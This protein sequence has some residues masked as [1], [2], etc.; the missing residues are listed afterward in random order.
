M[1]DV[2]TLR[3]AISIFPDRA[4]EEIEVRYGK[5]ENRNLFR[6][7][8]SAS[9]FSSL[10]KHLSN[11]SYEEKFQIDK[12][13]A[14]VRYRQENGTELWQRKEKKKTTDILAYGIR[15]SVSS[16]VPSSRE[17]ATGIPLVR[18][19]NRYTYVFREGVS[20]LDISIVREIKEGVEKDTIFEVELE[21]KGGVNDAP[22]FVEDVKT[23]W[24]YLYDSK[25]LYTTIEKASVIGDVN[26]ILF[27]DN[28]DI[29]NPIKGNIDRKII[30]QSRGIKY[31]DLSEVTKGYTVTLKADGKRKLL[32]C[33]KS[34]LWF[35]FPPHE[36]NLFSSNNLGIPVGTILDGELIARE[37]RNKEI[38]S[39]YYYL[40]F[41]CLS[42]PGQRILNVPSNIER[43]NKIVKYLPVSDT[44]K[45]GSDLILMQK[46]DFFPIRGMNDFY[47]LMKNLVPITLE[48][49]DT[50]GSMNNNP[51]RLDGLIFTPDNK[52]YITS[53]MRREVIRRMT[54]LRDKNP[55]MS[56]MRI[57][58]IVWEE[59]KGD[60]KDIPTDTFKWKPEITIDFTVETKRRENSVPPWKP[61]SRL[62]V[63]NKKNNLVLFSGSRKIPFDQNN[64]ENE[65]KIVVNDITKDITSLRVV[66]YAWRND[67]FVPLKLRGDKD[68]GNSEETASNNWDDIHSPISAETM[69]GNDFGFVFKYHNQVKRK[70]FDE[71]TKGKIVLDIGSG[72]GGDVSKWGA[73]AKVFAVEPD[74]EKI[75]ELIRRIDSR[76]DKEKKETEITV[77]N[78]G[79]ENIGEIS[80][81][82][83]D[84]KVDVISI[85]LSMTFF[86]ENK[87]TVASLVNTI[88]TFLKDGGSVIFLTMNGD[89]TRQT[90]FPIFNLS[91]SSTL[92]NYGQEINGTFPVTIKY[93]GGNKVNINVTGKI[94]SNQDEYLTSPQ[95]ITYLEPSLDL[96]K[97]ERCMGVY[98][99]EEEIKYSSL[100][101][102]GVFKMNR[103]AATRVVSN[104]IPTS[105]GPRVESEFSSQTQFPTSGFNPNPSSFNPNPSGFNPNPSSFNPNPN[106][107]LNPTFPAP[108]FN[109]NPTFPLFSS[110][111]PYSPPFQVN[112]L[113]LA[114][115]TP[116]EIFLKDYSEKRIFRLST[117]GGGNCFFHAVLKAC[118]PKYQNTSN[119][120]ERITLSNHFR[121]SLASNLSEYNGNVS[122]WAEVGGGVFISHLMNEL[123]DPR[124]MFDPKTGVRLQPD[125]SYPGMFKLLNSTSEVGDGVMEYV[126]EIIGLDIYVVLLDGKGQI[127]GNI[128]S[129]AK[130]GRVR[131]II[132]IQGN[133]SHFEI[134]V[135]LNN[136]LFQTI[137]A[138]NDSLVVAL[139]NVFGTKAREGGELEVFTEDKFTVIVK[140]A[141]LQSQD[142]MK[143][144]QDVERNLAFLKMIKT[145]DGEYA[146]PFI[147]LW[148]KYRAD[149][150]S[151]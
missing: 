104:I 109:P 69:M 147:V 19:K 77:I 137:F 85:M 139:D 40:I 42:I 10:R 31:S 130:K 37:D 70:L 21:F 113:S 102:Y 2:V 22:L 93:L 83:R 75:P 47:R 43:M 141:L 60:I 4:K 39:E 56:D 99:T 129:T 33:N 111:I 12:N 64:P 81:V 46:K 90:F 140:Q 68:R 131:N 59:F 114:D 61:I 51:Y 35:I 128:H 126:S 96:V 72:K 120:Q 94:V 116:G 142:P 91:S 34:G 118:Y 8:V 17:Q 53:V 62:F 151:L 136:G 50:N 79:G 105:T 115:D 32:V 45:G 6:S 101:S 80:R 9:A 55:K 26:D 135:V 49:F 134:V 82:I 44:I 125:Y 54:E 1:I 41:D 36:Y 146:D 71:N 133:G 76:S 27:K 38:K 48:P 117:L 86:W 97:Q 145:L 13:Y 73:A 110:T 63:V 28:K 66:E 100:F 57:N 132:I 98:M 138:P 3:E 87:Q 74:K 127:T 58:E 14:N 30:S 84:V 144:L 18:N 11:L 16:E 107:N 124:V 29:P 92:L 95:D 15:L 143:S 5:F 89:I 20:L 149:I 106:P 67:N 123:I 88:K 108:V 119:T 112:Y 24:L 150:Y 121:F 103:L 78:T 148:E 122:R 65:N 52:P 23:I 25:L 7:G